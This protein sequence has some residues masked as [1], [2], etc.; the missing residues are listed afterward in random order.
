VSS[1]FR[2][3][4]GGAGGT[5]QCAICEKQHNLFTMTRDSNGNWTCRLCNASVVG[6]TATVILL[7]AIPTLTNDEMKERHIQS[8]LHGEDA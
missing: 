8:F 4:G 3:Y 7:M 6:D 5:Q 1:G 2:E